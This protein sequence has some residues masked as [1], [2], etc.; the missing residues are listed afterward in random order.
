MDIV[1]F[2]DP[3]RAK[4]VAKPARQ[5]ISV[6]M[7]FEALLDPRSIQWMLMLGGGLLVLGLVIWLVSKGI[8]KDPKV[9]AIAMGVGSLAILGGGW[10]V[11]LKTRFRTAGQALTFL[12][13]VVAPMNL[14]F[15][16]AQGLITLDQNLWIGGLVCCLIYAATVYVL[17]DPLFMYAVEGGLTLT[18]L[19]LLADLH[20]ISDTSFLCLFLVGLGLV[21][22]HFERAFP[23]GDDGTFTRKRFGM[24]LFWSGHAQFGAGLLILLGTQAAGW[25]FHPARHL[26]DWTWEGNT[27]SQ[28]SLLAGGLW[29]AGMYGYLYSDLV[30]RR[31]GV[32]TYLAAFCL[33]L[34]QMTFV[35]DRLHAEGVI[36]VL[37]VTALAANLARQ[38]LKDRSE[39]IN[40]AVPPLALG[41]SALPVLLG[42]LIH[43]RATS[44]VAAHLSLSYTTGWTFV[45]V[46]VVVTLCNRASAY[47][48]RHVEPST[49]AV[50]FFFSAGSLIVA[51]AGLLRQ[52]DVLDGPTQAVFLMVIPLAYLIAA[53]LWR[54][55]S[56]ERPLMWVSH[57]ATGVVL[58]HVVL[59]SVH[60]L[61]ESLLQSVKGHRDNLMLGFVFA[62]AAVF[63]TLAGIFRK[64][65]ANVYLAAA[66]GCAALWQFIKY[67][68]LIDD[69]YYTMLYAL[70]GIA[71]LATGRALGIESLKTFNSSGDEGASLRGRGLALFQSGNAILFVALLAALLQGL[72]NLARQHASWLTLFA[73]MLTT[74]ASY[75]AIAIVP[76]GNWRRLYWT[77][78]FTLTGLCFLTIHVLSLL[79]GW[80]KLEI[81]CVVIGT[82]L[83]I[84]GY[85]ARFRET[86]HDAGET[87]TM[88]L[89]IG[90]L[91]VM[92]PLAVAVCYWRFSAGIVHW[93]DELALVALTLLMLVTGFS[94]RVQ[95]TT[96]AGG[97]TLLLYL[98]V[99]I[100]E[101]AY[102][103]QVATGVYLAVGGALVFAAGL[104]L[105]IYRDKLLALPDRIAK[106]EGI[107][108]IIGWR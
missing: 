101:L 78:S 104:V 72:S 67:G 100:G 86:E 71:A 17:R 102:R 51:A 21:S 50:Y 60:L 3:P 68:D 90:S 36:A 22:I 95:S 81:F 9:L 39:K 79:S 92:A 88:G 8:F 105:S 4:P 94:W 70:L 48:F 12:G 58:A 5:P 13:C 30:V 41:L 69:S 40:R 20:W 52:L 103:P 89:W 56:P 14:W 80:Q 47:L 6:R 15:Y 34:A 33:L 98:L 49:S 27:L 77:S 26:L 59:A 53:R 32:Y 99:T 62:E 87:L 75:L 55:H 96:T 97:G 44:A 28:H 35:W 37:A 10:G 29:L 76:R 19:L 18:T 82:A 61:G 107:F 43:V 1:D 73:L 108:Q 91:L 66:A 93:Q 106:R 2:L 11:M 38:Q 63:Y 25:M 74:A 54:G 16:H 65:S 42:L 46:M 85:I 23:P 84:S 24:P 45:G 64:R 57:A 7:M 83:V 31:V